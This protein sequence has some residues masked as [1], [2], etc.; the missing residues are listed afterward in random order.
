M[1]R[2]DTALLTTPFVRG[3]DPTG[4]GITEELIERLVRDF[5]ARVRNDDRLGPIFESRIGDDWE[6]HLQTMISF[7]S[8]LMLTTG[9]YSG[10][11][12]QKHLALKTIRPEDFDIWL[13]LFEESAVEIGGERVAGAFL[14]KANRVAA[15]FKMAM[16]F[17]S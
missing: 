9:R 4:N 3:V 14:V 15:S 17:P 13:R 10:R 11:P 5:Y 12:L 8:S 16:F 6:P 2:S 7:W 1:T